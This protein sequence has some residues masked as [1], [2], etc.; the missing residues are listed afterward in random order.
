MRKL[1]VAACRAF[2]R[3]HRARRGDEV[4]DTAILAAGG[5]AAGTAREALSLVVAGMRQRVWAESQRPLRDGLG[6][7]AWV[8]AVVNLAVALAGAAAVNP[9][10]LP[11][12]SREMPPYPYRP[13]WWWVAFMIAA[14]GIVLGLLREN[15]RLA[16][17][18]ALANLGLLAYDAIF[19]ASIPCPCVLSSFIY[20]PGFPAG[21][22]WL[23]PAVVLAFATAAAPLRRSPLRRVPLAVVAVAAL[24][25]YS[26]ETVGH[27][28]FLRW[29]LAVV[30]VLALA[31]GA[32]VPRL[33]VLA[34]GAAVAAAP[35]GATLLT[36]SRLSHPSLVA[37]AAAGLVFVPFA[38]LVRR[39]LA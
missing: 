32:L 37:V 38:R 26:R 13:D 31:F 17:A 30:L 16:L 29:P 36:G 25:V 24:V 23:A 11:F 7:L 34:V 15:R 6:P 33:A 12:A 10:F 4:V 14:G 27:F 22:E 18:A 19:P 39:R 5:S 21:R 9:P 1:L 3:D 8:L 2:P 35:S 28:L 20:V